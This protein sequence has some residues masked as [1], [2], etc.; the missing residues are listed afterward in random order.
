MLR[1][2]DTSAGVRIAIPRPPATLRVPER[3]KRPPGETLVDLRRRLSLLSPRAPARAD[4]IARMAQA[5]GISTSTVYRSLRELTRPKSVRRADHGTTKSAPQAEMERY[6]EIVAALKIRTSNKKGRRLSTRRAI[7]LL[8]DT[9][10]E[11]AG[12]LC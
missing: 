11:G 4:V 9:E 8:E 2:I 12:S 1:S 10:L 7:E 5:Y 6:A 3:A